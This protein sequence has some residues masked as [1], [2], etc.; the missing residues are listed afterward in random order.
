MLGSGAQPVATISLA[1]FLA[2]ATLVLEQERTGAFNLFYEPLPTY[3]DFV[4]SVRDGKATLFVPIPLGL[5]LALTHMAERLRL[6][7]PVKPGQIGALASN[8]FSPWRSDLDV[9]IRDG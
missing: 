2:A 6:R 9:L 3:R 1:D 7:I 8:E 4:R 5:A